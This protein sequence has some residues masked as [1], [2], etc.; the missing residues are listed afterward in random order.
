MINDENIEIIPCDDKYAREAV[1]MWRASKEKALGQKD[2]H[3]FDEH[4]AFLQSVLRKENKVYLAID[5]LSDAVV[6]LMAINGTLLKQ[7]YI[8]NDYQKNGIGSR[9]LNMAKELSSKA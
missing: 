8:H 9:L 4:L 3:S 5:K 6:G 1:K 2:V 7:L